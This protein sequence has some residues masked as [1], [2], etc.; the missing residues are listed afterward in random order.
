LPRRAGE[1]GLAHLSTTGE[2][3]GAITAVD[4]K[5]ASRRI[6]EEVYSKGKLEVLDEVCDRGL[7]AYDPFTGEAGLDEV[8]ESVRMYRSAF[9]DLDCTVLAQ[10]MDGDCCISQWRSRGTHRGEFMGIHPTGTQASMDGISI[11]RYRGGKLV[12][13]WWQ[14][15]ALGLLRQLGAAP[16]LGAGASQQAGRAQPRP[17]A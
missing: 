12:E 11:D 7:R 9:P 16:S 2:K 14:F 1:L 15:D 10:H 4:I 5:K 6:A 13:S 8:K 3:G 17:H